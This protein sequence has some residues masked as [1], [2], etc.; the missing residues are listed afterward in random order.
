[1]YLFCARF[2]L[3][4]LGTPC[5]CVSQ[6]VIV[7]SVW[8]KKKV[9]INGFAHTMRL[10]PF[11]INKSNLKKIYDV[12]YRFQRYFTLSAHFGSMIGRRTWP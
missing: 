7:C 6:Y 10:R 9:A 3:S 11:N 4:T 1:M 8:W 5:M 12:K 2:C